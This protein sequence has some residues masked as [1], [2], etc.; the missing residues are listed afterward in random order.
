MPK[1]KTKKSAAK[2][3]KFTGSGKLRRP[4]ANRQHIATKK[5]RKRK[6]KLKK[7]TFVS[8]ADKARVLSCLPN[9]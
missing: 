2:R 8:S 1:L 4:K 5:S 9:G 7:H 6:N 3:F